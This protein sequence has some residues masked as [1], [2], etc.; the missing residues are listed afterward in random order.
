ML[1]YLVGYRSL[2]S[3]DSISAIFSTRKKAEAYIAKLESKRDR[4]DA[5][6]MVRE[7]D[8][9]SKPADEFERKRR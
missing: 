2:Y 5:V 1:V 7:V 9:P 4:K 6:V 8:N 3:D